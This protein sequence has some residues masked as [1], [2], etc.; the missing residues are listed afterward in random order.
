M[1]VKSENIGFNMFNNWCF[2]VLFLFGQIVRSGFI[3]TVRFI[4][5]FFSFVFS[6]RSWRQ[7]IWVIK[8]RCW[9]QVDALLTPT[10]SFFDNERLAPISQIVH[11]FFAT[12][13]FKFSSKSSHLYAILSSTTIIFIFILYSRWRDYETKKCQ[14]SS[15]TCMIFLM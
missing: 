9:W 11:T 1:L 12:K 10:F 8:L 3:D 4:D 7:N 2:S 14:M 13:I 5:I 6:L 15:K